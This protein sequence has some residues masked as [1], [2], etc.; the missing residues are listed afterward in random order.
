MNELTA[1]R[2]LLSEAPASPK[3]ISTCLDQGDVSGA[4]HAAKELDMSAIASHLEEILA[5]PNRHYR[6]L[7]ELLAKTN[8][9]MSK[10]L[11][12][13]TMTLSRRETGKYPVKPEHLFAVRFLF[14]QAA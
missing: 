6:L 9:E 8:A 4:Y 5:T 14:S 12:I 13:N 7:R 3:K 1:I 10:E 11:G 2:R